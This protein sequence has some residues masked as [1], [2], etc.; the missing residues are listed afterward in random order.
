MASGALSD[1]DNAA[2]SRA[3]AASRDTADRSSPIGNS[4]TQI[5]QPCQYQ[6]LDEL[7]AMDLTDG[8][9]GVGIGG[10]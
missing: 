8:C 2:F 1:M 7:V 6:Q 10:G 9:R 4:N 3:R 5:A